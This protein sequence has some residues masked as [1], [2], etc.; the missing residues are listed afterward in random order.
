MAHII[1]T[2]NSGTLGSDV[3]FHAVL[4]DYIKE[5]IPTVYLLHGMGD[6]E[7][8]WCRMTSCERYAGQLGVA[9]IMP[10]V[11]HSYYSDMVNGL[12]YYTFVTDELLHRTRDMFHLSHNREKTFTAGLSMGGYGALKIALRNP[13]IY[14]GAAS[15]SGV[16]DIAEVFCNNGYWPDDA[17]LNWGDDFKT[18]LPGSDSDLFALVDRFADSSLPKPRI[19]QACGTEDFLYTDNIRFRD[20]IKD[21]GFDYKYEEAP[22]THEWDFWDK[23]LR[24][25]IDFIKE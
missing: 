10:S 12:P 22:G 25:A 16:T 20:Y 2:Y 23:F 11:R 15:L 17:R 1:C 5:D 4:P 13:E 21:K 18:T 9:L 7:T 3:T 14:A 24:P 8:T 19:Y 6:N